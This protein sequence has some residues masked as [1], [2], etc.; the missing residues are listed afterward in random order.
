MYRVF[1]GF[2][3]LQYLCFVCIDAHIIE[4]NE[5]VRLPLMFHR[6]IPRIKEKSSDDN[7]NDDHHHGDVCLCAE[8]SRFDFDCAWAEQ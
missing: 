1:T 2:Y 6:I 5:M 4:I 8:N 3:R 7:N